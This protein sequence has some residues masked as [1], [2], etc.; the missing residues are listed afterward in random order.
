METSCA[1]AKLADYT[2]IIRHYVQSVGSHRP[3]L[4]WEI[5]TTIKI[6]EVDER[7]VIKFAS[8]YMKKRLEDARQYYMCCDKTSI[9]MIYKADKPGVHP[10]SIVSKKEMERGRFE[11][12]PITIGEVE[13]KRVDVE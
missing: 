11:W 6:E 10:W 1:E 2:I 12:I 4:T 5:R 7:G 9:D 3:H 13:I 8:K